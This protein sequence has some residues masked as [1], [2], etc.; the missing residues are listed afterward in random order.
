MADGT[1]TAQGRIRSEPRGPHWVAWIADANG[2]PEKSVVLVGE[3]QEE[4]EQRAK[5]WLEA[6]AR[7]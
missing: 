3:T 1:T 5:A 7:P 2:R 4:A 6:R